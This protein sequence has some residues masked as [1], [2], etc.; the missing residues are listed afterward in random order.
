MRTLTIT[1]GTNL[2]KDLT[3]FTERAQ[4]GMATGK[5]QGEFLSFATAALFFSELTHNRWH[6]LHSML[7]TGIIGVRALARQLG[8]D[9]RRVHDDAAA[10]VQ[11][12]LLEK[13]K[14]GALHCPW[15]RIHVDITMLAP[16]SFAQT[17]PSLPAHLPQA[18]E[19]SRYFS[20]PA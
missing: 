10:L 16:P 17:T 5:Y 20:S 18:G 3:Q 6:M 7:G 14:D 8:R 9:V 2:E 1:I 15:G 19:E 12:G 13:T 11:L 4:L